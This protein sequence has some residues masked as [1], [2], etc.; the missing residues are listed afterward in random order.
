MNVALLRPAVQSSTFWVSYA[1]L[2][3]DSDLDTSSCTKAESEPW[4]SVD[5]GTSLDVA[6][7][8]ITNDGNLLFG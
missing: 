3:V 1:S 7:V 6:R 4:L 8:C 2:A 5:L